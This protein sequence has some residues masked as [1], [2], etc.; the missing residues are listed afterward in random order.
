M[1][2]S[3]FKRERASSE[4]VGSC[5]LAFG[6]SE[7]NQSGGKQRVSEQGIRHGCCYRASTET[8][9]EFDGL[10]EWGQIQALDKTLEYFGGGE[11]AQPK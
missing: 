7:L 6:E 3:R 11:E 5:I 4:R 8:A 10:G 2:L 1:I 9:S